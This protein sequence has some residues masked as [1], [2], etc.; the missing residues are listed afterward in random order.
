ML[1]AGK[2]GT[3]SN[4][5]IIYMYCPWCIFL[6]IIV[7]RYGRAFLDR[8]HHNPDF[9]DQQDREEDQEEE[10]R[11]LNR[12]GSQLEIEALVGSMSCMAQA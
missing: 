7:S 5:V 11:R 10:E 1:P 9:S 4:V 8:F 2:R 12:R 3:T 6:V